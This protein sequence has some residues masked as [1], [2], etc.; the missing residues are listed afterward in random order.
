M[1]HSLLLM[2]SNQEVFMDN[3]GT[4]KELIDQAKNTRRLVHEVAGA[5]L[6]VAPEEVIIMPAPKGGEEG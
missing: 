5:Y 6:G 2:A 3:Q 4:V 1:Y